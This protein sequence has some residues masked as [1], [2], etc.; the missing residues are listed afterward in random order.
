MING[1]YVSHASKTGFHLCLQL[2]CKKCN[3]LN[4]FS[5]QNNIH[6]EYVS[7]KDHYYYYLELNV[8]AN[9]AMLCYA[10]LAML[11]TSVM[12]AHSGM[13]MYY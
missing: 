6:L 13:Y 2:L 11:A 1:D 5:S 4:H 10:T 8:R 7:C 12:F 9:I 3:F